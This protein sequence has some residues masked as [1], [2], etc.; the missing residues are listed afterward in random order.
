MKLRGS[1]WQRFRAAYAGN[2]TGERIVDLAIPVISLLS[3]GGVAYSGLFI[4]ASSLPMFAVGPFAPRVIQKRGTLAWCSIGN[5]IQGVS[6]VFLL[7]SIM[8][9][10][11]NGHFV[12]VS[13][14]LYGVGNGLF[15]IAVMPSLRGILPRERL[16]NAAS[17]M[18]VIDSALTLIAPVVIG[19][20]IDCW[21]VEGVLLIAAAFQFMASVLRFD[22][23]ATSDTSGNASDPGANPTHGSAVATL[24]SPFS[25]MGRALI[26]S[27]S[28]G[29][30]LVSMAMIPV[31]SAQISHLGGSA[32]HIGFAVAATGAMGLGAAYLAGRMP[33]AS[34]SISVSVMVF[35]CA[36]VLLALMASVPSIILIICAVGLLDGLASWMYVSLPHKRMIME[37]AESLTSIGGGQMF[38]GATLGTLAGAAIATFNDPQ[39]VGVLALYIGALN[40]I[41]V[42][43][44]A[45]AGG[46][47]EV[48]RSLAAEDGSSS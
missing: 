40:V 8:G 32:S 7:L 27:L 38:W 21:N 19:L 43:G 9:D 23:S 5:A 22:M 10:G 29:V 1:Q 41:C 6:I 48:R 3:T 35:I 18:E 44:L 15:G 37:T 11:I 4:F 42:L 39:S 45:L 14:F 33:T 30:T 28:L 13:G 17:S 20:V 36:C 2:I 16:G 25:N 34:S 31:A 46:S 24:F 47:K 12:A 26:S